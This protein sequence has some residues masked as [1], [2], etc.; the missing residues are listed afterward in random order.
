MLF[1][2]HL[3]NAGL[4]VESGPRGAFAAHFLA[5]PGVLHTVTY[6]AVC[7]GTQYCPVL[8]RGKQRLRKVRDLSKAA[9]LE[10]M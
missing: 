9:W 3:S 1:S 10:G 5:L 7:D 2:P 4:A 6:S 8:Q